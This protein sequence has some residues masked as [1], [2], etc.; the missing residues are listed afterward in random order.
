MTICRNMTRALGGS[1]LLLVTTWGAQAQ[2]ATA[3]ADRLKAALA[4]QNI[5][6]SWADISGDASEMV[7]EGVSVKPVGEADPLPIGNI[8][9]TGVSEEAGAYRIETLTT[10]PFSKTKDGIALEVSSLVVNG[11]NIPAPGN[12]DVLAGLMLYESLELASLTVQ[13]ADKTAFAMQGLAFE[14]TPPEDGKAMEFSGA[15]E[16][17]SADLSLVEDPQSRAVIEALG[18]QNIEGYM[19]LAGSWQ[20]GDGRLSLSQY[21]IAIDDAGTLGMTFDFGGYTLD[22][23][24]SMQEMSRKMAEQPADADNSAQGMA[25][26]GL[27]QQLSIGGAS[28]R[29]D[30]DSLTGKVLDFFG[31]QQGMSGKDVAN[32]AKAIVPF[33]MAQLNNPEL[34]QQVTAA[35][36]AFLDSPENIEIAAEPAA[37]VPFAVIMAGAMSNPLDLPKTLGVAVR[38][39]Q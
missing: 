14:M 9:L 33:L 16:K 17:F 15:A 8:T 18:Y 36:S 5:D 30:D 24:K 37:A 29:F 3:V 6:I 25:M 27:M 34:T 32:Q 35:V 1:A 19:E 28:V 13:V 4:T 7:L 10:E 22:F 23:I 2:D 20:P 11:M 31:K 39:N 38:A 21:D 12:T 26:L